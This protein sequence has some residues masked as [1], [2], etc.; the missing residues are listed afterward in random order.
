MN[1]FTGSIQPLLGRIPYPVELSSNCT[2]PPWLGRRVFPC[3]SPLIV[4]SIGILPGPDLLPFCSCMRNHV[5]GLVDLARLWDGKPQL[6]ANFKGHHWPHVWQP[7]PSLGS[8]PIDGSTKK[9]PPVD[10][11]ALPTC[12]GPSSMGPVVCPLHRHDHRQ[13]EI[14]MILSLPLLSALSKM[15]ATLTNGLHGDG[16]SFRPLALVY[17]PR[18]P[19]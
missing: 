12:S 4:V 9:V 14:S 10:H 17:A 5:F 8:A 11:R 15:M 13:R 6:L 2:K 19:T 1:W 18:P 7:L 3:R 16:P